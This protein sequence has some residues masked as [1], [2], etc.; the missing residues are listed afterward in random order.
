MRPIC[1]VMSD[2]IC[3][4]NQQRAKLCEGIKALAMELS[5][6]YCKEAYMKEKLLTVISAM[7]NRLCLLKDM[8]EENDL[9]GN[10]RRELKLYAQEFIARH[11]AQDLNLNNFSRFLGYSPKYCSRLFKAQTGETFS[12]YTTRLRVD[13]AKQMLL[14]TSQSVSGI[15]ELVGFSDPFIFSHFFKRVVG[16]SPMNFRSGKSIGQVSSHTRQPKTDISIK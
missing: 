4:K 8:I 12:H 15:A 9:P 13:M 14:Q 10:K 7:G 3:L 1:S 6:S 16:C 2:H 11:S 5:E